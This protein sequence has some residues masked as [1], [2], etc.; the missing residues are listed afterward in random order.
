MMKQHQLELHWYAVRTKPRQESLALENLLRQGFETYLPM[1]ELKKRRRNKWTEVIEPL[2][3]CYAFVHVDPDNTDIA[4]IRST[5]GVTGMVKFGNTL[6][7]VPDPVIGFLKKTEDDATGHHH[8]NKPLFTKGE[9]VEIMEGP[10]AGLAGVYQLE[11]GSDR[12]M[13]LIELMGRQ[14]KV[15]VKLDA[16]SS[17]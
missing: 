15:A 7:P 9:K 10:F 16:I 4:P 1:I 13:I 12:A 14:N 8:S 2:F 5:L 17:Q 11:K 3:P 6:T